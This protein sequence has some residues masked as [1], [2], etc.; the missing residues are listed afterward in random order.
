[1]AADGKSWGPTWA[2][3]RGVICM[4]DLYVDLHEQ[5]VLFFIYRRTRMFGKEWEAISLSHFKFGIV[6]ATGEKVIG[7][8]QMGEP[9]LLE[10][11]KHLERKGIIGVRRDG[12][13]NAANMYRINNEDEINMGAVSRYVRRAQPRLNASTLGKFSQNRGMQNVLRGLTPTQQPLGGV[14][15]DGGEGYP[16][17]VGNRNNQITKDQDYNHA[18]ASGGTCSGLTG[19]SKL[20]KI[21]INK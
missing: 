18:A 21:K 2:I 4:Y 19:S 14:P 3:L 13:P 10:C 6:S 15:H 20:R 1:M 9:K 12:G 11:L 5:A 8:I 7:P 16:T 17:D